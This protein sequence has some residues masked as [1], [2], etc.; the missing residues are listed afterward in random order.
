M[1]TSV[2]LVL[3]I[4]DTKFACVIKAPFGLPVVPEV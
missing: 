4:A 1:S 3:A 2:L